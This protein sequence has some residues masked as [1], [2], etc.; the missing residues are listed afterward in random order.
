[1]LRN[2][3]DRTNTIPEGL[4]TGAVDPS[5]VG[6]G[7]ETPDGLASTDAIAVSVLRDWL[8]ADPSRERSAGSY[9][10]ER[11]AGGRLF[12]DAE[13]ALVNYARGRFEAGTKFFELGFGFGELSLLLALS[14]FTAIGYESDV[15]RHA[16][17]SALVEGLA[18]RGLATRG[19][20]LVQG[21]FPDALTL[22][23]L[24]TSGPTVLVSTNVTSTHI[25]DNFAAVLT[26][27]KRFDHLILDLSRFGIVR[28]HKS[29]RELATEL[30][31]AGFSEVGRVHA[32]G[33][34][35]IWHF[36]QQA[37][38]ARAAKQV[39][40]TEPNGAD[41][42][43]NHAIIPA[44]PTFDPFSHFD[45]YFTLAGSLKLN[46]CPV[47]E[48][49]RI[50]QLWSLPQSRLAGS[51]YLQAPGQLHHNT[52]L[53]YL[54]L[55]KVPQEIFGFDICA[56]CHSI[57]RNPK[58]DDQGVY[59]QDTSKVNSFKQHGL[60]PFRGTAAVCE[61]LFPAQTHLV[62]D[63]ACGS[64]QMLAIYKE[65]R[66][67]LRLFGLEL[68]APSVEWM[69]QLGIDAAVAD[70][71]LDDLD[72]HI[73]PGTVDF[74]VFNE[75]FEHVRSPLHVLK[76]MFRMLRSGGRI[77]FTA[78]YYGP[79][80]ELQIRVGEPIYIDRH[81]LDWVI[82]QLDANLIELKADIKYRVTLEKK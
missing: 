44:Q 19:V 11:L 10:M 42:A 50:T 12:V 20:S 38:D 8:K 25:M 13:L 75:A 30:R 61:A 67:E 6:A 82:A 43:K 32:V 58:D 36:K 60:D 59:K 76:K 7:F 47:C 77:H 29:Q 74:I 69:K 56:E 9:Y 46:A 2:Q 33:D 53:D 15:G 66:P 23:A 57:F 3:N 54:P 27:L 49:R 71:D 21:V 17:A 70:L 31:R 35:D 5:S 78:Q 39:P 80:N 22:S 28:D 64:G 40:T 55:L 1:M 16:G 4:A 18:R 65:K 34:S 79:E 51:T 26:A 73:A 45:S 52:Y 68:S 14:G 81:G 37:T 41:D 62:V 63:A 72:G 24:E 48:S